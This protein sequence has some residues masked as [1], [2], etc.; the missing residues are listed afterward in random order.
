MN[1][2]ETIEFNL[3]QHWIVALVYGDESGMDDSEINELNEFLNQFNGR[4][5]A[6]DI[7]ENAEFCRDHISRLM[8]DCY[9]VTFNFFD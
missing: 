5:Y 6:I 2:T 1:I 4:H 8:A 9:T 3:S 7:S